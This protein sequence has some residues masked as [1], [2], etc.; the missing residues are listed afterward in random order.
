[1]EQEQH[2][3][4]CITNEEIETEIEP[5][6]SEEQ[7]I[8]DDEAYARQLQQEYI[9]EAMLEEQHQQERMRETRRLENEENVRIRLQQDMEYLECLNV[10]PKNN[11]TTVQNIENIPP[12][13]PTSPIQEVEPEPELE[14]VI[15]K[16]PQHFICPISKKIIDIPIRDN[17]DNICYDKKSLLLY[18]KE[19]NNKN[20]NGKTV[21]KQNLITDNNLKTEIFLWLR[22]HPEYKDYKDFE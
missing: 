6:Q 11:I 1:M 4:E 8:I 14:P 19:N 12:P 7:M 17:E 5:Q 9:Q 10:I 21:D 2:H 22:D 18:L 16:P 13:P 15:S 20:H 3:N